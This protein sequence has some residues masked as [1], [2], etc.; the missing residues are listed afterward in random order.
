MNRILAF[1]LLG[2]LLLGVVS[3]GSAQDQSSSS[4]V[5]NLFKHH[6]DSGFIWGML[7]VYGDIESPG[8]LKL[9]NY[10]RMVEPMGVFAGSWGDKTFVIEE[11]KENGKNSEVVFVRCSE[12]NELI[13]FYTE[14]YD[15]KWYI[16]DTE[17]Y[18]DQTAQN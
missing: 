14:K 11:V 12:S 8:P 5:V 6:M 2:V 15:G 4:S 1:L 16:G 7:T 17:V 10:Y 9:S 3:A 13:K 18:P